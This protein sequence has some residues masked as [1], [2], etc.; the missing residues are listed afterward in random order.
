MSFLS[1]IFNKSSKKTTI[2]AEL[3]LLKTDVHSHFIPGID[4]G[5]QTLKDSLDLITYFYNRGYKKVITTPHIMGD[6]YRNT[7]EII[8]GGLEVVRNALKENQ[9]PIE[10]EAAAEYYIDY[11]FEEK[12]DKG[13][14]LSF[15]KNYVLVE[16]S[17]VNPP[18]NLNNIFFKLQTSGYRPVLAHPERYSFWHND[19]EKYEEI[20]DKGV[21]LQLNINSLTGH[22]S[23]P[24]K[25]IAEQMIEKGMISFLGSDCH[26]LGHTE[27]ID[28]AV[29]EKS[30]HTLLESGKLLNST[31]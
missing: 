10:I 22:Y 26:H 14:L 25:R 5:A 11:D 2:A 8:L 17:F 18:D 23:I 15:G 12:I 19:F 13:N 29:F 20:I 28:K 24:T 31:L 30:L 7:P 9:I 6:A 16:L 4:D 21:L 3:A 27:L 1:N